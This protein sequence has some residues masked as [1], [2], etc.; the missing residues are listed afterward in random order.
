MNNTPSALYLPSPMVTL[1]EYGSPD[2]LRKAQLRNIDAS[3]LQS[4]GY[5]V[6]ARDKLTLTYHHGAAAPDIPPALCIL[7]LGKD[8]KAWDHIQKIPLVAGT[9]TITAEHQGVVY[10]GVYHDKPTGGQLTV[11][12]DGGRPMPRFILGE[13]DDASWARM[14]KQF[15]TAPY[16]ELLGERTMITARR[17]YVDQNNYQFTNPVAVM[18]QWDKIVV[19]GETLYGIDAASTW[20][21]CKIPQRFHFTDD[22]SGIG[23]MYTATY[24]I[25]TGI[26]DAI[27]SVFKPE[28]EWGP[29]HEL[30]HM[31]QMGPMELGGELE[32]SVNITSLYVQR[33]RGI[34][35]RLESDGIWDKALAWLKTPHRDYLTQDVW[36]RL[37]MLWQLDLTF[38]KDFY[39]RLARRYRTIPE[40][41]HGYMLGIKLQTFVFETSQISGYDLRPF[42]TAWGISIRPET[43][44]YIEKLKLRA[45]PHPI[46]D[47]RDSDVKFKLDVPD[48]KTRLPEVDF[49]LATIFEKEILS[50]LG[51]SSF[52]EW[53]STC[54]GHIGNIYRYKNPTSNLI[55]Y[56]RL[57]KEHYGYFPRNPDQREKAADTWE[58]LGTAFDIDT[59][60]R[61]PHMSFEEKMIY[62]YQTHFIQ[63]WSTSL[64]GKIG[65]IYRYEN[66]VSKHVEYFK[67]KKANYGYYPTIPEQ[68]AKAADTWEYLGTQGDLEKKLQH[69]PLG[70]E[71]KTQSAQK[72]LLQIAD[73]SFELGH[74]STTGWQAEPAGHSGIAHNGNPHFGQYSAYLDRVAGHTIKQTIVPSVA[75]T[76]DFSAWIASGEGGGAFSVQSDGDPA[77]IISLPKTAT[78]RYVK[79]TL[80]R[81]DITQGKPVTIAF[82]SS[83]KGWLNI[84]DVEI[85]PSSLANPTVT[86]SNAT[87]E[88]M[89]AWAKVKANSWVRQKGTRG[90][91][92]MDE[93]NVHRS[94]PETGTYQP[95]YWAGYPDRSYFYSRDFAHQFTGAHVIGLA[96]HNK[97]MLKAFAKSATA[98]RSYFPVWAINF[99]GSTGKTDYRDNSNFVR[100][101][102]APFELVE[103]IRD[104]YCWTSDEDY[105]HDP[106]LTAFTSNII[107]PFIASHGIKKGDVY[108]P[109]GTGS[110]IWKGAASYNELGSPIQAADA[111]AALFGAYQAAAELYSQKADNAAADAANRQAIALFKY[112]NTVWSHDKN[113][114]DAIVRSYDTQGHPSSDWGLEMSWF[115]PI[116]GLIASGP[117]RDKL[118]Q[119]IDDSATKNPPQNLEALTYL[120]DA[121]FAAHHSDI[122]WKWMQEIFKKKDAVHTTGR[123]LNSDYPEISFTLLGQIV[124]GLLGI[125]P[126]SG[127]YVETI[128]RLPSSIN[129]I[130]IKDLH[131][132]QGT[133]TLRQEGNTKSTFTF[134]GKKNIVWRPFFPGKVAFIAINGEQKE[135]ELHFERDGVPYS[136]IDIPVTEGMEYVAEVVI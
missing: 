17:K 114:P 66:P 109:A 81:I 7:P 24:R 108:I 32:V 2:K 130:E 43:H 12:I 11:K 101:L 40:A 121:F 36:I 100:E 97:T 98:E 115:P 65:D 61:W 45:L 95:T 34:R 99:D 86:S 77:H 55:E 104:G 69:F 30:G 5:W 125:N 106:D 111:V 47:N 118:M 133:L 1:H 20:P 35:S 64:K 136:G 15:N 48:A 78:T 123:F 29:W 18:S 56:F 85:I 37:A 3:P 102:P 19:W 74:F 122:A 124:D 50:F 105:L 119:F 83:D 87:V 54:S 70:G 127:N 112:F 72:G 107:G 67:L 33:E 68:R 46:Q 42:F 103:R 132:K 27:V 49:S 22:V 88:N 51:I 23:S 16:V 57:K 91:V 73:A 84:D 13:H 135:A 31:L 26:D 10:I 134:S 38:G 89:F 39:A 53:V 113:K 92:N 131:I 75:E 76:V 6:A 25:G 8:P 129:W 44:Q 71:V 62:F 110:N 116:K 60:I 128:A 14:L 21:N 59:H 80:P 94:P 117:R 52:H 4:T 93:N 126:I 90:I 63:H 58:Y 41:Q 79:Y 96:L 120:P 28:T 9:Q 82:H